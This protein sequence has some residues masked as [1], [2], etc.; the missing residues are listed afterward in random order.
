[1]SNQELLEQ[2][3]SILVAL[4]MPKAQQNARTA[5]CLMALLDMHG[6]KSWRQAN[7]PLLGIRGILDFIRDTLNNPIAENT[8][9]TIRDESVKP[10]VAAGF[11]LHNPDDSTRA[12]N[13][14]SN[15]Y[16]VTP[17]ALELF[18]KY[19]TPEWEHAIEEYLASRTT[20]RE[21]YARRRETAKV[22][23]PLETEMDLRISPGKH[24]E[25]IKQVLNV[26]RPNFVPGGIVIYIGDTGA[27]WGYFNE[28]A[29]VDL[30][31]KVE[32]HGQ[33]PDVVM[34][35]PDKN[36]L[37]LIECVVSN[38]PVDGRRYEELKS[39]FAGCKAKLVFVTAF[40]DRLTMRK[41][42]SELAWETE[43][44]IA[45]APEHMIHF[46]GSRFLGPHES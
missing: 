23:I 38:G 22:T 44:W 33:M 18:R 20:L 17:E 4:G 29:L 45:D 9:E 12:V 35:L 28:N 41:H 5:K 16:Q 34:F 30:G 24:S 26:F 46:N 11:V 31:V 13:S 10:M 3:K 14:K 1:M 36:W 42:L 32:L 6:E 21:L 37:F 25:L 19:G 7:A 43:V 40:Q 15:A 8:R 2:A 27:K 39:I